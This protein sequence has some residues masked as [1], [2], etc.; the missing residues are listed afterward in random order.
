MTLEV[1]H[2][3]LV[4]AVAEAGNISRAG[5]QLHL[6]QSAL[7]HQLQAIEQKLGVPLF[8]RHN[9]RMTLSKSGERLLRSAGQILEELNRVEEDIRLI[10]SNKEGVLRVSTECSTAYHWLPSIVKIFKRKFP[11]ITI[12]VVSEAAGHPMQYLI[13]RKLDI[14][15]IPRTIHDRQIV[16]EP[17]FQDKLV[18]IMHPDHPLAWKRYVTAR[19]FADQHLFLYS[20]RERT[21]DWTFY[22]TVLAA[23]GVTPRQVSFIALTEGIIE[24]VKAGLGI[25]VFAH[26][27]IDPELKR[28]SI[29]ALPITGKG[30]I[31]QWNAA[32]LK[33]NVVPP[34]MDSFIKMLANRRMPAMKYY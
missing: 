25:A 15:I 13:E 26:W 30:Y 20:E 14:A 23:S 29:K 17:L 24:M 5:I 4:K 27:A 21:E 31:R 12:Q 7:S 32:F 28:H 9:K 22:S 34:H 1:R 16:L 8:L 6:T 19:D 18:V 10:A 3:S 33:D 11:D 2:L